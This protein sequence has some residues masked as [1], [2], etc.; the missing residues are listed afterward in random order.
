MLSFSLGHR[1]NKFRFYSCSSYF[2]VSLSTFA[3]FFL[4]F[5]LL[6]LLLVQRGGGGV[7]NFADSKA[8]KTRNS[9]EAEDEDKNEDETRTQKTSRE[10][11][12]RSFEY[13]IRRPSVGYAILH[14]VRKD[15]FHSPNAIDAVH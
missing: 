10:S 6:H 15:S 1:Y 3:P 14:V 5:L 13:G 2:S 12:T 7:G 11:W 8:K 4:L 9:N